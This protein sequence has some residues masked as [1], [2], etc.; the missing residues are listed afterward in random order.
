MAGQRRW[1]GGMWTEPHEEG[2]QSFIARSEGLG[3]EA[4]G[5]GCEGDDA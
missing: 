3:D 2:G 5:F 1:W 4:M